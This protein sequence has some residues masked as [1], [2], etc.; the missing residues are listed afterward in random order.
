MHIGSLCDDV[1]IRQIKSYYINITVFK[2]KALILLIYLHMYLH[3]EWGG[4][5]YN[6]SRI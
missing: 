6:E 4:V 3:M 2:N 1:D 5:A